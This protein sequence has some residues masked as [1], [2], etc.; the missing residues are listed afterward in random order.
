MGAEFVCYLVIERRRLGFE[1]GFSPAMRTGPSR[2]F[3][4]PQTV[5][6]FS[7]RILLIY[8]DQ[9]KPGLALIHI[10]GKKETHIMIVKNSW[11]RLDEP[12]F[13]CRVPKPLMVDFCIQHR[14]AFVIKT[15]KLKTNRVFMI[16]VPDLQQY[17]D[18]TQQKLQRWELE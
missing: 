6:E 18:F 5:V 13:N 10:K 7:V 1:E 3:D 15:I 16:L 14:L 2:Q 8:M 4:S 12:V 17:F 11:K 9:D